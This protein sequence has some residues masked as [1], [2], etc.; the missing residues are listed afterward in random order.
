MASC[1]GAKTMT[2]MSS[3]NSIIINY[4]KQRR[5]SSPNWHFVRRIITKC[6]LC[7]SDD[8]RVVASG[9][10]IILITIRLIRQNVAPFEWQLTAARIWDILERWWLRILV[11]WKIG[12]EIR[13]LC[14][15]T[16]ES[17]NEWTAVSS[18]FQR[19]MS[20]LFGLTIMLVQSCDLCGWRLRHCCFRSPNFKQALRNSHSD[21]S[22]RWQIIFFLIVRRFTTKFHRP[23]IVVQL[24]R[25]RL[26]DA[27]R[28]IQISSNSWRFICGMDRMND[29]KT[30]VNQFGWW[31]GCTRARRVC[32][33]SCRWT[34]C[35]RSS[36]RSRRVTADKRRAIS[37]LT[38][39]G[40]E[41]ES[42]FHQLLPWGGLRKSFVD[43]IA[44]S[45][46]TITIN[47]SMRPLCRLFL[48]RCY[49]RCQS[50]SSVEFIPNFLEMVE[51]SEAMQKTQ[52][53]PLFCRNEVLCLRKI[54]ITQ[55][56]CQRR[57]ER[58]Q[59]QLLR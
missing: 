15:M 20:K 23:H 16:W 43:H 50:T 34:N 26:T 33:V 28:N 3:N 45:Y 8:G 27:V 2:K 52:K 38:L 39:C 36:S 48:A 47:L 55:R 14:K 19:A 7:V 53:Y 24:F 37:T 31:C 9:K 22:Q 13:F 58:K 59:Q 46:R 49:C 51:R 54:V 32:W 18:R 30:I 56:M 57:G 6:N 29:T 12:W 11:K 10:Q 44:P 42:T 5:S 17:L 1:P 41:N 21:N 40:A 35:R 25:C 4:E